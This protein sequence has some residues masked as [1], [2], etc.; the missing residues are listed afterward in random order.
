MGALLRK[1]IQ[2][3]DLPKCH[4]ERS[5]ITLRDLDRYPGIHGRL[6]PNEG[7]IDPVEVVFSDSFLQQV[8]DLGLPD[9]LDRQTDATSPYR[10]FDI[11]CAVLDWVGCTGPGMI[12]IHDMRR[13][14]LNL[15]EPRI[16]QITQALYEEHFSLQDLRYI[17]LTNI[18]QSPG[19]PESLDTNFFIT[20]LLYPM[21][22]VRWP[23]YK[24][25][26]WEIGTPAYEAIL[27]SQLG[28]IFAYFVLGA[29]PRGTR[30]I[31][32]I[33]VWASSRGLP[34]LRFDIEPIS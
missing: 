1:W 22:D 32:G 28:R 34:C 29:F 11:Q 3:P 26:L 10:H 24:P 9:G 16:S 5:T 13:A 7:Q 12:C 31:Q 4:I 27:G 6:L 2:D 33:A 15:F 17:F 8:S 14:S 25:R 18:P 20:N 19:V 30:Q 21:G 23:V